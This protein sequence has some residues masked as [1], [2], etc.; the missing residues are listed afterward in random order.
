[1]GLPLREMVRFEGEGDW[2]EED[3]AGADEHNVLL[4]NG[5][6]NWREPEGAD[7]QEKQGGGTS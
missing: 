4:G 7:T 5:G 1:M 2:G 3:K 6:Q